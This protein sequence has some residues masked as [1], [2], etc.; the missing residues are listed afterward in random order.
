[1]IE[2][3]HINKTF[4]TP[5]GKI[6]VL[7]DFSLEVKDGTLFGIGGRSG[8]GKSTILSIIA[9]L[10]K[11]SSGKV[12]IGNDVNSENDSENDFPLTDIFSLDDKKLSAFRNRNIGFV[13][14]EQ[15]FLENLSVFDNV[16]LPFFLGSGKK[17][18]SKTEEANNRAHELLDSLGIRHLAESYP[19][20][21][22][23][24]ENHRVLIAR[25][26]MNNPKIILADEPTES[27]DRERTEQIVGIFRKL[28]DEGK[29][30]ILVSHDE[31][32]LS[33]CDEYVNISD[34]K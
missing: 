33:E 1:M 9:G 17:D 2:M 6:N 21:L 5:L 25:A 24:G 8:S 29:T 11:P 23:G 31:K 7:E 20:E 18:K 16:K 27:V 12:L 3:Q 32:V 14:Q 30:I 15:S 4:V 34:G 22:S 10:Q 26:L 13:S 28:S 19:R